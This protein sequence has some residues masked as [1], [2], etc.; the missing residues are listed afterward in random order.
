M[1]NNLVLKVRNIIGAPVEGMVR[2]TVNSEVFQAVKQSVFARLNRQAPVLPFSLS[3]DQDGN[4]VST[5]N[6]S[7]VT[8][9]NMSDKASKKTIFLMRE[10]DAKAKLFAYADEPAL[11]FKLSSFDL[12]TAV[13][14]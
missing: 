6:I 8:L 4:Y 14:A 1:Y 10:S 7:G 2:V 3:K 9:Y 5:F 11:P 13:A 12:S